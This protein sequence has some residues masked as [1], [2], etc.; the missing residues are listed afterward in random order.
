MGAHRQCT[1]EM[2]LPAQNNSGSL[3][4]SCQL[5][6]ARR[7]VTQPRARGLDL[8]KQPPWNFRACHQFVRPLARPLVEQQHTGCHTRVC[9]HHT[10]QF[11]VHKVFNQEPLFCA[12]QNGWL[13][14]HHPAHTHNTGH[15]PRREAC[16]GEGLIRADVRFPPL[17]LGGGASAMPADKRVK[18]ISGLINRH[19]VHAHACDGNS[20]YL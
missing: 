7:N 12:L 10:A 17:G 18:R 19:T 6:C 3:G 13:M 2:I 16:D 4:E 9:R 5:S 8:R 11:A 1:A 14:F 20:Y 15:G